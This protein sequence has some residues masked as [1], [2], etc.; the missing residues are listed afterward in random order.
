MIC[1][2]KPNLHNDRRR[3][4]IE[5]DILASAWNQNMEGRM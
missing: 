4:E 1:I 2:R 3:V 5:F